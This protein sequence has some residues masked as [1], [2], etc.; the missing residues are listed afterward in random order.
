MCDPSIKVLQKT[1]KKA[2][3]GASYIYGELLGA[4]YKYGELLGALCNYGKLL[5]ASYK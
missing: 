2:T 3:M 1:P 5:G 4:S